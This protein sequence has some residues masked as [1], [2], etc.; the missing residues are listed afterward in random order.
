VSRIV[1]IFGVKL[2]GLVPGY[3]PSFRELADLVVEFERLGVDDVVDGEHV[4]FAADMHHPGGSGNMVHGRTTQRSDRADTIVVFATIAARTSRIGMMSGILLPAVHGF[5]VLARQASTLDVVSG[6]RFAMGVGGGWNE[7]EFVAQG[8]PPR[9]RGARTE[10][11]IRAC[12]ELWAPGP[13]SFD[14]VNIRFA[15]V[16]S[17]PAP[18]TPGGPPVWWGGDAT[19]TATARR[20]VQ[21]GAGWLAREAADHD[22][23]A[24][25]IETIRAACERAGRDPGSVGYRASVL[26]TGDWWPGM[27]VGEIAERCVRRVT[28]L[29]ALGVTH[30]TIPLN[31]FQLS[32]DELSDLLAVLRAAVGATAA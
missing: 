3:A 32:L 18:V 16:V 12:R 17:E 25:S 7:A 10:E 21:L 22:E 15:E 1:A 31:Y 4:L 29:D 23:V 6:G 30:F 26:P 20:V 28:R 11:I 8:I 13:S 5:A 19:K 27:S 9:E 24:R 14:G 2:P